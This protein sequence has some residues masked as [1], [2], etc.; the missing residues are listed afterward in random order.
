MVY[1]LLVLPVL[2]AAAV[3]YFLVRSRRPPA[4]QPRLHANCPSCKRRLGYSAGQAGRQVVCPR[5]R[6]TFSLPAFAAS[7]A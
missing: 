2:A 3:G 7:R 4:E 6:Q 5:C 1:L